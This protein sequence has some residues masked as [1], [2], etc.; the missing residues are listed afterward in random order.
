LLAGSTVAACGSSADVADESGVPTGGKNGSGSQNGSGGLVLG[1]GGG[2]S[3]SGSSSSSGGGSNSSGGA[4]Q[5]GAT[6][7]GD[8]DYPDDVTF[9]Y[10]MGEGGSTS[11][12]SVTGT[13]T[14]ISR[15]MDIIFVIDDSS[16]MSNEIQNVEQNIYNNFAQIIEDARVGGQPIDYR[17]IMVSRYGDAVVN[18]I[19]NSDTNFGICIPAPFGISACTNELM[20]PLPAPAAQD[21]NRRYFHYSADIESEDAACV[22]LESYDKPDEF[23]PNDPNDTNGTN[24]TGDG[25]PGSAYRNWNVQAPNGWKEWLRPNAFKTF[26]AITDDRLNCDRDTYDGGDPAAFAAFTDNAAGATAVDTAFLA[27]DPAQFGTA[28]ARNY[29]FHTIMGIAAKAAPNQNS[30]YQPGEAVRGTKCG[31]ADSASTGWEELSKRTN[32]LRYPICNTSFNPVFDA[33]AQG[34]IDSAEVPCQYDFPTVNGIINPNNI[35]VTF[36]PGTGADQSFAKVANMGACTSGNQYYFDDNA[37]P[38]KLF[39]CGDACTTV[40]AD[41]AGSLELDFGCLGS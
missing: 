25:P 37:N 29:T 21:P 24:T 1:S 31:S 30:A 7:G 2:N 41:D 16:S 18:G 27:L 9:D 36:K 40:Q 12:A 17:V 13:P 20:T 8:V 11:C 32:G 23:N 5:G 33:I 6:Y 14:A 39:L 19:A 4:A 34:V 28:A 38:T 10:D 26:V 15:P 22:L 3:G 35:K